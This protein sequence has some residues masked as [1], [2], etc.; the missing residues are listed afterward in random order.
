MPYFLPILTLLFIGLKLAGFITWS[1]WWVISP[2]YPAIFF[3]I[4]ISAVAAYV[5]FSD[6]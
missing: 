1:W 6:R 3:F 4:F 5:F 2:L